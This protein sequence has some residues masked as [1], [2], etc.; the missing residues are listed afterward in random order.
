M[1]CYKIQVRKNSSRKEILAICIEKEVKHI[2][3]L[4]TDEHLGSKHV[5]GYHESES[6]VTSR[7]NAK[8]NCTIEKISI[9]DAMYEGALATRASVGTSIFKKLR[10]YIQ[11]GDVDG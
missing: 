6:R 10:Y 4:K 3:T 8:S 2:F 9:K 7:L 11:E 5:I 1:N